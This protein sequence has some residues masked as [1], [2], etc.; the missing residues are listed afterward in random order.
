MQGAYNYAKAML[1]SFSSCWNFPLFAMHFLAWI[2]D[3]I[4]NNTIVL[5]KSEI[6]YYKE[7][8]FER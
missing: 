7:M 5:N 4:S 6:K 8:C 1:A 2:E 3:L